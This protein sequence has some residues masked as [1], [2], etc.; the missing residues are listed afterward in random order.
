MGI[1]RARW[2][3][4]SAAVA[5]VVASC[6]SGGEVPPDQAERIDKAIR[7]ESPPPTLG[8]SVR[9]GRFVVVISSCDGE[10]VAPSLSAKLINEAEGASSAVNEEFGPLHPVEHSTA[11]VAVFELATTGVPGE[12]PAPFTQRL[13]SVSLGVEPGGSGRLSVASEDPPTFPEVLVTDSP[14]RRTVSIEDFADCG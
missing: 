1:R 9:D 12:V 13:V 7:E 4:A 8:S 11:D 2:I 3:C 10:P 6:S 5:A 14:E